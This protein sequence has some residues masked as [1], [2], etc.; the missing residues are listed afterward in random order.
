MKVMGIFGR[1]DPLAWDNNSEFV[2]EVKSSPQWEYALK[3][4]TTNDSMY[5]TPAKR[6]SWNDEIYLKTSLILFK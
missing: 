5:F 6:I 3:S 4:A 2:T 1:Y